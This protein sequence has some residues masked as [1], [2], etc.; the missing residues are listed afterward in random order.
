MANPTLRTLTGMDPNP[1]SISDSALVLID[2][3]QTYREGVMALENVEPALREAAT[4][5]KRFR[6]VVTEGTRVYDAEQAMG[7]EDRL[8][9]GLLMNASHESLRDDFEVSCPELNSLVGLALEA[10]ADQAKLRPRRFVGV[11]H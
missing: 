7:R 9:F 6:H 8:T 2:C 4:L 11:G 1:A 5:L 3:Q 10:G